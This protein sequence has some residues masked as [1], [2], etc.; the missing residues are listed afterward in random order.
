MATRWQQTSLTRAVKHWPESTGSWA[1]ACTE[2]SYRYLHRVKRHL[3]QGPK[4]KFLRGQQET[5]GRVGMPLEN[6]FLDIVFHLR[7]E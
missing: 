1:G 4:R 3:V 6:S 7:G 5:L 2:R